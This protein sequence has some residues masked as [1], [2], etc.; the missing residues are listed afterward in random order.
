MSELPTIIDHAAKPGIAPDAEANQTLDPA[1]W[2]SFRAQAHLML[3]D[4]LGYIENI[5]ERPVWQ[6]IPNAVRA[7]FRS[8][9]PR[10]GEDL[11]QVHAEFM[12]EILPFAVGNVHPGFMG[13]VHGG[14]TPVRSRSSGRW[15]N[16]CARFSCFREVRAGCSSPERRWQI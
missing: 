6:P 5:R 15:P 12:R 1:D 14:G 16:G 9:L 3:D 7:R 4:M 10:Q 11:A 2:T 13:W 8:P